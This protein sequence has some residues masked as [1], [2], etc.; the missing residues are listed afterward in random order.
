MKYPS[1]TNQIISLRQ[2]LRGN[3]RFES[4]IRSTQRKMGLTNKNI[5]SLDVNL[6]AF[7]EVLDRFTNEK[8]NKLTGW[9][10]F[11]LITRGN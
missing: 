2:K 10:K 8:I 9:I 11:Y 5:W 3:I 1:W 7:D 4:N 6:M